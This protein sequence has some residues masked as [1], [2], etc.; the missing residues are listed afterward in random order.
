MEFI[1]ELIFELIFEGGIEAS[2]SNKI[3]KWIRYPLI[4][5]ITL[6]FIFV[7]GIMFFVGIIALKDN[8]I[9]GIIVLLLA[10]I[11]LMFS[12]LKFR[13]TYIKKNQE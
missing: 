2:K 11:M 1:F 3:P 8:L 5:L 12:I 9:L 10:I 4:L 6:F 13:D 7:I